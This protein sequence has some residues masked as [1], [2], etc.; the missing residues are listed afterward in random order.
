MPNPRSLYLINIARTQTRLLVGVGTFSQIIGIQLGSINLSNPKG[1]RSIHT[2]WPINVNLMVFLMESPPI[3]SISGRVHDLPFIKAKRSFSATK[4][5]ALKL[6]GSVLFNVERTED[7]LAERWGPD[8]HSMA[9][10]LIVLFNARLMREV[11]RTALTLP[12][13]KC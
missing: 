2:E 1:P 6:N 3:L 4:E 5:N 9:P 8:R 10:G 12:E 11:F 7:S 13:R